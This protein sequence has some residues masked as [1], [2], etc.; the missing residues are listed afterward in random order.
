LSE[1]EDQLEKVR[2]EML[3]NLK[4]V[5]KLELS[6]ENKE[7]VF[8]I[9]IQEIFSCLEKINSDKLEVCILDVFRFS[10]LYGVLMG[11]QYQEE[12]LAKKKFLENIEELYR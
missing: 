10:W 6:E 12:K 3:D 1:K 2:K 7:N 5:M 11:I 4:K 9:L 8:E